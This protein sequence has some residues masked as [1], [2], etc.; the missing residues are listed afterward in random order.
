MDKVLEPLLKALTDGN[1]GLIFLIV[2]IALISDL[3]QILDFFERREGRRE[4]FSQRDSLMGLGFIFFS[5]HFSWFRKPYLFQLPG[6]F[7]Q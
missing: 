4:E 1:W 7:S 5:L 2:A 6:R 3:R